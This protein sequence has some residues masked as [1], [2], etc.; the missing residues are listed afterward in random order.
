METKK[1]VNGIES[2]NKDLYDE[3]YVNELETRLETDPLLANGLLDLVSSVNASPE[4][5]DLLCIACKME[6]TFTIG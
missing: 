5:I 4:D 6:S 1:N 3:M 2:I